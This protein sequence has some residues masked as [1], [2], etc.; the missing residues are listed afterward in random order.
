MH[1][2]GV[3]IELEIPLPLDSIDCASNAQ[4]LGIPVEWAFDTDLGSCSW[5]EEMAKLL[6][7]ECVV[8]EVW[9]FIS[10]WSGKELG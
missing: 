9:V 7:V 2:N 10:C 6:D 8:T 4:V 1:G 5:G 3:N